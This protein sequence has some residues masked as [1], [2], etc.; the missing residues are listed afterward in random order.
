VRNKCPKYDLKICLTRKIYGC[1]LDTESYLSIV[2][3]HN[4]TLKFASKANF[5]VVFM[6]LVSH[7]THPRPNSVVQKLWK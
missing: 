5:K 3:V 2:R 7:K 4:T 6:T 1:I